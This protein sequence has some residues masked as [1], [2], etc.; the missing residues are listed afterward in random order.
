MGKRSGTHIERLRC[1]SKT[2]FGYPW[3]RWPTMKKCTIWRGVATEMS[4]FLST[5]LIANMEQTPTISR[6]AQVFKRRRSLIP[7][8]RGGQNHGVGDYRSSDSGELKFAICI[9]S[10]PWHPDC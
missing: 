2:I 5:I 3:N 6:Y 10:Y 4:T 9:E 8:R 7:S 1:M